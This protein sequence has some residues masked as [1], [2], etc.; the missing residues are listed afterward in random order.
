VRG[1]T[2]Y[3]DSP[4]AAQATRITLRHTDCHDEEAREVLAWREAHP[5]RF[6]VVVTTST[7]DSMALNS[8]RGGA[9][10]LAGSGM[11][12]AGRIK[13]HLKH[14]LWRKESSIV[15]VGFQAEG[16]LGR[17]IVDGAKWVRVLGEDIAVA[18]DIYTIGGLSAHADR[19]DLLSW[20][21]SFRNPPGQAFVAHGEET[22][23]LGFAQELRNRF[24]WNVEVPVP[25][26]P[27]EV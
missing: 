4:L 21:G 15:I 7:E 5:E 23:S 3:I 14:N 24:R 9:I 1:I 10:I 16:T 20:A 11:C 8:V 12:E 2:L 26:Q 27:M 18:A 22:V 25:G 13:H 6:R 17:R 19:D